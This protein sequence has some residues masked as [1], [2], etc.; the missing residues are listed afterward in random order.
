MTGAANDGA[1]A[2]VAHD[3][4]LIRVAAEEAGRIALSYFH[5]HR[6]MDVRMKGGTSPVSAGDLAADT[7][8][9][10]FLLKARPDYGWLSEESVDV[11]RTR[12]LTAQRSFVVDPI[13]GT[14]A[15]IEGRETWCV[16]VAVVENGEAVAGVLECPALG[17]SF[18]AGT[19]CGAWK[20][21]TRLAVR[22]AGVRPVIAAPKKCLAQLERAFPGGFESHEHIPSLAYR[23]A[24]IAEGLLDATVVRPT[25]HDWDIAAADLI[26]AEAGGRLTD[27]DGD[28]VVLNGESVVKPAMLAGGADVVRAMM[29]VVTADAFG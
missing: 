12:R 24:M 6:E 23:L 20:G 25:A 17:F 2:P 5:G 10:E 26:L 19:G 27:L 1:L 9:R 15:F 14:R 7:F 18:H 21:D 28:P 8:L 11:S 29:G 4:A 22:P 16:S 3:L 13:D